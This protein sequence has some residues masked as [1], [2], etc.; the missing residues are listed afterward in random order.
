VALGVQ[1]LATA[2]L[3]RQKSALSPSVPITLLAHGW[4]RFWACVIG[5]GI[6]T[7]VL[8][9]LIALVAAFR[10]PWLYL[11][12]IVLDGHVYGILL[13]YRKRGPRLFDDSVWNDQTH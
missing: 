3:S 2:S 12:I 8:G 6:L 10:W 1:S 5:I 13:L 11:H 9:F 7:P 4:S